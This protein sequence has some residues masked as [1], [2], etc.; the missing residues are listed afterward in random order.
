M[1]SEQRRE[2]WLKLYREERAKLTP[3]FTGRLTG[4]Q[5]AYAKGQVTR[6]FKALGL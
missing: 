5:V 1:N 6:R 4:Q 3:A 2:L